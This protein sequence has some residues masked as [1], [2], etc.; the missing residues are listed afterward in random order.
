MHPTRIR[1]LTSD[2]KADREDRL[3][4]ILD[5]QFGVIEFAH[6]DDDEEP[7]SLYASDLLFAHDPAAYRELAIRIVEIR[8]KGTTK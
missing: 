7:L 4:K 1:E 6:P 2:N 8:Q 3:D 5:D